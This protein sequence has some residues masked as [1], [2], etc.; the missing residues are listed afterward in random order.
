MTMM[1]IASNLIGF[2]LGLVLGL[3]VQWR[4][5]ELKG[6]I[7]LVPTFVFTAKRIDLLLAMGVAAVMVGTVAFSAYNVERERQCNL[8]IL[9]QVEVR[10]YSSEG[11]RQANTELINELLANGRT[12]PEQ[13]AAAVAQYK[14][15]QRRIDQYITDHPKPPLVRGCGM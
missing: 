15:T 11:M 7:H 6:R 5:Q 8:A 12:T 10:A 2:V 9:E 1:V 3:I 13:R 14:E 4:Q